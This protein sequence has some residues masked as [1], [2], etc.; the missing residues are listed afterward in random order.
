MVVL[1]AHPTQF[2]S[3]HVL[4]ILHRLNVAF[5]KK[6]SSHIRTLLKQLGKTSFYNRQRLTPIE[7]AKTILV[8]LKRVFYHNI[9]KIV[10]KLEKQIHFILSQDYSMQPLE[11]FIKVGF[12]PGGDRD[13]NPF[14][15][16]DISLEVARLLKKSII[17]CY[18]KDLKRL[19]KTLTFT[20]VHD[21]IKL[22]TNRLKKTLFKNGNNDEDRYDSFEDFRQ[23]LSFIREIIEKKHEG[24]F[25]DKFDRFIKKVNCFEFY[26]STLDI[27]QNSSVY[28]KTI[29]EIYLFLEKKNYSELNEKQKIKFLVQVQKIKKQ[30][31]NLLTQL[32]KHEGF[33][34]LTRE[35]LKTVEVSYQIQKEN[36][37]EGLRRYIIS[38]SQ[39]VV[40]VLEVYFL[41]ELGN[42][43]EK[44]PFNII[45]LFETMQDL[46]NVDTTMDKLY[47]VPT[48]M[49]H[50]KTHQNNQVVMLGFSDGTKDGGYIGANWSIFNAKE[51]ITRV[52]RKHKI[53]VV[54]FDGRGGPPARGGGETNKFYSSLGKKIENYEIQLTVQ[55]QTISSKYG[56]S[57]SFC[58]N[59][60]QLLIAGLEEKLFGHE[61]NNLNKKNRTLLTEMARYSFE[62]YDE[63]KK[64]PQFSNYLSEATPLN[65]YGQ[66]NIG[67]RP[68]K[69][70]KEA[71]LT[72]NNLRAIPFVSSWNQ[73]KQNIPAYYGVGIAIE[74]M[75]EKGKGKDIIN[76]Y[77]QS[78]FFR[79]LMGNSMQALLKTNLAYTIH[80]KEDKKFHSIW[81][82]I[83]RETKLANKMIAWMIG[84]KTLFTSNSMNE[85]SIVFREKIVS[86]LVIIQQYALI[87][88]LECR[89]GEIKLSEK[90]INNYEK[91]IIRSMPGIINAGR[92]SA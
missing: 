10:E 41:L 80:L 32:I 28:T 9:P 46:D 87:K 75:I 57:K 66:A 67:S 51:K 33:E 76:L 30:H 84:K 35:T 5:T 23:H 11:N 12:W 58:Y 61:Q 24:I 65:F 44:L 85:H 74:K 56:T 16:S 42:V 22:A 29:E 40:N 27:R 92:N 53:K 37:V 39:S 34:E 19:R 64:H 6:D 45:P 43:Q 14:V 79:T 59:I 52:S 82:K 2:Y 4:D 36:G 89:R 55:G 47:Q 1:T 71:R 26:F 21:E 77:K 48:Y 13:G 90:E 62:A 15:T 69:R 81:K 3:T 25:L 86:P 20:G 83:E 72:L 8:Y 63:L 18:V 7:E 54:F 60:E 88:L 17:Q 73:V 91:I 50:L 31:T 49:K 38:N 68:V 70:N 78:S